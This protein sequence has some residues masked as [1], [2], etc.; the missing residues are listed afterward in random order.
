M[1]GDIYVNKKVK[2]TRQRQSSDKGVVN[3]KTGETKESQRITEKETANL[4]LCKIFF[5]SSLVFLQFQSSFFYSFF[6]SNLS[7]WV[8]EK[9]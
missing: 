1:M 2:W 4:R 5:L 6:S 8:S 3:I 9:N 7:Y